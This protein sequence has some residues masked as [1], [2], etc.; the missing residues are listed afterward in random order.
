MKTIITYLITFVFIFNANVIYSQ[1]TEQEKSDLIFTLQEE[2][3]AY[4]FYSEMFKKYNQ[5]VFGNIMEAEKTHQENVLSVINSLNID[6]GELSSVPGEFSNKEMIDEYNM[7]IEIGGYSF[8][9][10]L[11][12]ATKYEEQD[13]SDLQKFYSRAENEQIK[14]LYECLQQA[15]GNHLR[16]FVRNLKKEG[17]NYKPTVLSE[18]EYKTIMNSENKPGDCF[19]K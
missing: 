4:D 5:K 18:E 11:R 19:Q 2:K 6:A 13:I 7:L 14:N 8:T 10:A 3:V 1:Y 16:A 9:D 15:T 12:A 17:I